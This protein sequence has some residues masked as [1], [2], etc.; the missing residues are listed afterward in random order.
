MGHSAGDFAWF[1]FEKM[2]HTQG[3]INKYFLSELN[4]HTL[5]RFLKV[6]QGI[7]PPNL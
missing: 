2:P 5:E 4:E 3:R 1:L 6:I 7:L